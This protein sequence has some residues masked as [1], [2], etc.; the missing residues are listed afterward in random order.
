MKKLLV[1]TDLDGT[2]LDHRDYSWSEAKP[3]LSLLNSKS[4]PIII[5][6][7]KTAAEITKIAD[8][9]EINHPFISENGSV[10]HI[11]V[12]YF[13][14]DLSNKIENGEYITHF[15]GIP[16]GKIIDILKRYHNKFKF[17]GFNDLDVNQVSDI[18]KL[19]N[20]Q[21]Y[22]AKQREATEPIV[23]EDDE[24]SLRKFED[25]LK[26]DG[27]ILV[28]GGRFHHVMASIDKGSAVQWLVDKYKKSKK[29]LEYI[30]VGLGDSFNDV[31]M[32][33]NVDFPVLILNPNI[34]QPDL[35][36]LP[37]LIITKHSGPKGWNDA[38]FTIFGQHEEL[39]NKYG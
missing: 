36:F 28:K 21:A 29:N 20:K 24:K 8:L 1:F 25:L 34:L 33:E 14:D 27:L 7:S 22:D 31:R 38:L 15:F 6:S 37:N 23:W 16:Y 30:T 19:T 13:N 5:N 17:T 2:L 39:R 32:L 26:S 18:C 10:V 11:P 12:N 4:I 35:S 3:A 9:L